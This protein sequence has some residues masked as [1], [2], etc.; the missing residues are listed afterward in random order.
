MEAGIAPS[1]VVDPSAHI[2]PSAAI[3]PGCVIGK[4]VQIA[5]RCVLLANVTVLDKSVVG[6]QCVLY[7]GVVIY[8]RSQL[9]HDVTLHANVVIGADG[10]GYHPA[11]NVTEG[12]VKIPQ[13]GSVIIG[14][15]VEIGACTCIDRGKFS[16]TTIGDGTKIDNHCQVAHNCHIGRHC[17][18]AA[19][20]ALAGSVI[21]GDNAVLAG[22]SAVADH[23]TVGAGA[24]LAARATALKHVP[25]GVTWYGHPARSIHQALRQIAALHKLPDL[26]QTLRRQ[27]KMQR[28]LPLQDNNRITDRS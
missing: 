7:P 14:N 21:I 10:F 9:G 16:A 13:I 4:D 22:K 18:L 19:Q 25:K 27:I 23:V 3:G 17:L 12:L 15:D 24:K 11:A 20:V 26:L 6:A 2:H 5:D 8:D 28:D 1:A